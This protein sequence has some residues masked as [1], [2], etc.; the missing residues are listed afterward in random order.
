MSDLKAVISIVFKESLRN[1]VILSLIIIAVLLISISTLLGPITLGETDRVVK[2]IGLS[3]ISFF[4]LIIILFSG[5]RLLYQEINGKTIYIMIAKPITRARFIWGKFL[6]LVSI[7]YTVGIITGIALLI[8]ILTAG[9]GF[10][11][12]I[13][14]AVLFILLQFTL[15]SAIAIFFSTF[16]SPVLSGL[17][18]VMIYIVGYLIKDL[19][20]FIEKSS[21]VIVQWIVRAIMIIVPNFYYTDIKINAVNSI[22]VSINY[23]I[24]VIL[25]II[26][27]TLFFVYTSTVIFEN[28][29]F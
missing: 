4:S 1:K 7:I 13:V 16:T 12:N 18:T 2:D 9:I 26:I 27:Y 14:L 8:V 19:A 22:D 20:F 5:T 11:W 29:E 21:S 24:F 15:L 10:N 6:G 17:F 28:K 25:Y 23:I 3:V